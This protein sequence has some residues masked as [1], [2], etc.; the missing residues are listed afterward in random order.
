MPNK[1]AKNRKRDRIKKNK[2]LMKQ[3]RTAKQVKRNKRNV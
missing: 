1:S 2:Q 3:G